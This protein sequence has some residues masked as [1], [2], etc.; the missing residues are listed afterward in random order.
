MQYRLVYQ[1]RRSV[2]L[3]M[4]P[5]GTLEVRAPHGCPRSFIDEC[6]R[7]RGDWVESSR[8]QQARVRALLSVPPKTLQLMGRQ[9]ACIPY[10]GQSVQASGD[11]SAAYVPMDQ[12]LGSL[13]PA[14]AQFYRQQAN[15]YL[16]PRTAHWAGQLGLSA[17][18]VS[19]TSAAKRWGS[20]SSKG[21]INY[22]W[23]LMMASPAA[24]DSVIIHELLHLKQ[25]NHS[26]AFRQLERE[27][28]PQFEACK[29]ELDQLARQLQRGGW[30]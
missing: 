16:A 3:R 5:D 21:S 19:V 14:L 4:G 18:R 26:Q 9:L 28:T 29:Q 6:V 8:A 11:G 15:A 20:C 24:I 30:M 25:L 10:A 13:M 23:R 1:R 27:N 7:K 12:S 22:S 17:G 2:G